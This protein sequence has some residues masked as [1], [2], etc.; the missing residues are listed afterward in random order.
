ME[1]SGLLTAG[2]LSGTLFLAC[3]GGCE[4]GGVYLT[5]GEQPGYVNGY[6]YYYY[7]DSEV[8][9]YP[10]GGL[11]YWHERDA[12]HEGRSLPGYYHVDRDRGVRLHLNTNR[13]YTYHAQT[14]AQ[15]PGRG[16]EVYHR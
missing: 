9:F 15:Y 2:V 8:Y 5:A 3:G 1:W 4:S 12:W 11:Y 16:H 7:P 13:P 14:R 10:G 6:D